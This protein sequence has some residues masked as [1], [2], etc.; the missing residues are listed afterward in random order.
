MGGEVE[1]HGNT[2]LAGGE[3]LAVKG[4]RGFG[5][6]KTGILA[7][8]PGPPGIHGGARAARERRK[9]R[10]AIKMR[11]LL[12]IV[13]RIEWLDLDALRRVPDECVR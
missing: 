3:R 12:Q 10:Q 4:I 1:S 7:D 8:G 2:L 9:A 5:R 11:N 6:G 13:S